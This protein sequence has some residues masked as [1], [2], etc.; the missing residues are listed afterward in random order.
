M[1]AMHAHDARQPRAGG[2]ATRTQPVRRTRASHDVSDPARAFDEVDMP[3]PLHPPPWDGS[4]HADVAPEG[5]PGSARTLGGADP[6][7][8][9]VHGPLCW[10]RPPV[11]PAQCCRGTRA[12][13]SDHPWAATRPLGPVHGPDGPADAAPAL[14]GGGPARPPR[15]GG[16]AVPCGRHT[17][18]RGSQ[19]AR[20]AGPAPA[21]GVGH[22]AQRSGRTPRRDTHAP[23]PCPSLAGLAEDVGDPAGV[24]AGHGGDPDRVSRRL[25]GRPRGP[26]P[27]RGLSRLG[28]GPR[29]P[30]PGQSADDAGQ[31]PPGHPHRPALSPPRGAVPRPDPGRQSGAD[32]R[33]G[34]V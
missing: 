10:R 15:A 28:A 29:R 24:A 4:D 5:D 9:T 13:A 32:A 19:G 20:P 21:G 27:A 11:C 14:A 25:A 8:D 26:R 2:L 23:G 22:A 30:G 16:R 18:P 1:S 33:G 3:F 6:E 31:S 7:V 34:Q 12:G 17:C